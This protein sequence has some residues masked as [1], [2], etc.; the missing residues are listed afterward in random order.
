MKTSLIVLIIVFSSY[1]T[2]AQA[3]SLNVH[4][5]RGTAT[6]PADYSRML[7]SHFKYSNILGL[8]LAGSSYHTVIGLRGWNDNT[9]GKAHELAFS[10]D[11]K[12]FFRSGYTP[13]WEGWRQ[14]LVSNENGN[15]G[16]GTTSPSEKLAVNGNILISNSLIPMGLMT[17]FQG[18]AT[19]LL[20]FDVNF[21]S[22]NKDNTYVGGAFRI[23]TR[24]ETAGAPLFQWISRQANTTIESVE[25]SLTSSGYLGIGTL[26]PQERLSVNGNIRA[27]E[28]K[29]ETANWPDYVFTKDYKLPTLQQT[30]QHIKDKGHLPGIPSAAEVKANGIDLGEMN[31]KL[32]QKIEELTLHL[33][34][35]EKAISDQNKRIEKL[36]AFN[37]KLSTQNHLKG[38]MVQ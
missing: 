18:T 11:S 27:R 6:S 8:P 30:E 35:K 34:E 22:S 1:N 32:L 12:L 9:G 38:S 25:M 23:D 37:E 33:I 14:V 21:R 15:Y 5:T 2:F 4:D 24:G 17:E 10:D 28:I 26:S 7:K 31:V 3:D 19:P 16:I 36:E 20:N 13:T 29:V